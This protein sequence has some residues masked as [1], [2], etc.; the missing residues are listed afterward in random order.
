MDKSVPL[1]RRYDM[2]PLLLATAVAVLATAGTLVSSA[3]AG[4]N[5]DVHTAKGKVTVTTHAGWHVNNKFP[6]KL[7]VGSVKL[8]KSHFSFSHTKASV[9]GA[10]SGAGKLRGAICS[11]N[12]CM[13]FSAKVVV[14]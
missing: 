6:W 7:T 1:E 9:S 2:R 3:Q 5:Y 12:Q 13:P 10:P 14:K 4:P 8:D 11:K